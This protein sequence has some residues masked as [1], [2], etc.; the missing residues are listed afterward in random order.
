MESGEKRGRRKARKRRERK[1]EIGMG[2][3]RTL[4]WPELDW[5]LCWSVLQTTDSV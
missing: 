5:T 2:L 1:R 4:R 3:G